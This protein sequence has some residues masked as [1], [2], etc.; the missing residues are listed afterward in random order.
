[1]LD[2]HAHLLPGIDD[3]PR[4]LEDALALARAM[5]DDGIE[6]VVATPHIYPGVFD[7]TPARIADTFDRFQVALTEQGIALT[8]S[9]AAEVRIGP[10]V[11]EWLDQRR[12]PLL[13][14]SLVGPATALIELPDGQIPVGTDRLAGLMIE[15]GITPLIAHPERNKAVME[16]PTRLEPLRRLGCKFQVTAASVLGEFGSRAQ[17]AARHLL[18][19]GWVDVLATDAHNLSG[20]RPRLSAA[21]D[22]IIAHYD[23]ALAE[24]LTR[25]EPDAIAGLSSFSI[26]AGA[27]RLVFRDLP[28]SHEAAPTWAAGDLDLDDLPSVTPATSPAAPLAA[29]AASATADAGWSLM[30]FRIDSVIDSLHQASLDAGLPGEALLQRD[31]H[32]AASEDWTLPDFFGKPAA[33]AAPPAAA[34]PVS[35][36]TSVPMTAPPVSA[37]IP[38][39]PL[40]A[41]PAPAPAERPAAPV[42]VLHAAASALRMP[43]FRANGAPLPHPD[44]DEDLIV[45]AAPVLA[46][47]VVAPPTEPWPIP[48]V[49][50]RTPAPEPIEGPRTV[51][52]PPTPDVPEEAIESPARPV[53]PAPVVEPIRPEPPPPRRGISLRDLDLVQPE[54]VQPS[55]APMAS[56]RTPQPVPVGG[57]GAR[58]PRSSAAGFVARAD[59]EV[60]P[61]VLHRAGSTSPRAGGMA[62]GQVSDE[63]TSGG[64]RGLRL[65]DMPPLPPRRT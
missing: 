22:W 9:W 16:Q 49:V 42:Q 41:M 55:S 63:S 36:A 18:D 59:G 20:R 64:M 6:H 31:G 7:N 10:E 24:R 38:S 8:M 33:P 53:R 44:A 60:S 1:M 65:S 11:L 15:R 39:S 27:D 23:G 57:A 54:V 25:T 29:T 43:R 26:A 52:L 61:P 50:A 56:P 21:R 5:V 40:P 35:R 14:G 51:A 58:M 47:A 12:L 45:P 32:P 30:D 4:T 28:A 2:L 17:T 13:N 37:P 34:Q 3:G 48:R 46:P 19:A 62:S